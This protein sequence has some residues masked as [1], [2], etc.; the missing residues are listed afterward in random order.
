MPD[1]S[2]DLRYLR[3]ALLAAEQ[4]SFRRAAAVLELSQST[5]SRRIQLLERRLGFPLFIRD[6]RGVRLT[7]AGVNF[8]RCAIAGARHLDRAAQLAVAVHRGERGEL[9]VGIL[10]SLTTG[11]LHTML[12]RFREHHPEVQIMLKEGTPPQTLHDLSMGELDILFVAGCSEI[13]GYSAQILWRESIYAAL[14]SEHELADKETISWDDIREEIF[15]VTQGGPG[16]E[17]Q[18]YL[19]RRLSQPG[20]RPRIE[21]HDVSRGSLL[22]LVAM[23]Y[24]VALTSTSSI[25]SDL[26]GVV[27][28]AVAGEESAFPRAPCGLQ[29]T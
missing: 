6:R 29:T 28:R 16:V 26:D 12:R 15:V 7:P 21:V 9:R 4:G 8:L 25:R 10:A 19:I 13:A 27:F 14:P 1:L 11:F 17:I 24:G 3:C 20:F 22:D 2:F 23:K 18:D 5:L